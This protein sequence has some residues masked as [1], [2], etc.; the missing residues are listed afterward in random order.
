M[1]EPEHN[2]YEEVVEIDLREYILLLWNKKWFILGLI[3]LAVVGAY[4]Y[5]IMTTEV[6]YQSRAE[7]LIMSPRYTEIDVGRMSQ[8]NYASLAQSDSIYRRI[9]EEVDLRDNEGELI[10]PTDIEGSLEL[11]IIEDEDF[12]VEGASYL[13]QLFVT[14]TDPEEASE[15]VNTWAELVQEDTLDVRRGEIDD[16][17]EVTERRFQETEA[18]LEEAQERL[19]EIKE[20]ARLERLSDRKDSYQNNIS[21]VESKL[22][23]LEEELG[24]KKVEKDNLLTFR[25]LIKNSIIYHFI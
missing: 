23:E 2:H 5:T 1:Q 3:V 25:T 6:Q 11:E 14:R 22:L 16:I 15:I 8:S 4:I 21:T 7:L 20:T 10:N 12:D 18:N 9:I 13:F 24:S 19:Q 17:F